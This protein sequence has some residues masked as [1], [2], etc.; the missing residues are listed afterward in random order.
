MRK[1]LHKNMSV[2]DINNKR[3]TKVINRG[4]ETLIA[5]KV[6]QAGKK[7]TMVDLKSRGK[8]SI[9]I[10]KKAL[11]AKEDRLKRRRQP[12]RAAEMYQN[13][14]PKASSAKPVP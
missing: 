7:L 1:Q 6:L 9:T 14:K 10:A 13:R 2:R 12:A 5:A 4:I 8:K 11:L 3:G